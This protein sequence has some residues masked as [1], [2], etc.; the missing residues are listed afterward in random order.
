MK[1]LSI[2]VDESGDFGDYQK[3]CPFYIVSLVFHEQNRPIKNQID[4]LN[5]FLVDNSLPNHTIH[6]APLIRQEKSYKHTDIN[7]RSKIFKQLFNFVR[8][9]DISY[10]TIV[11]DKRIFPAQVDIIKFI[12]KELSS[13]IKDNY[14]YFSRFD[15]IIIYYDNGQI[16]LTKT[17]IAIFGSLLGERSEF[18]VIMPNN[19]KLF[20]AADLICTLTLIKAK[21]SN[22]RELSHS[23]QI[24]FGSVSKLN[25]N[26]LKFLGKIE[27]KTLF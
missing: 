23:E 20:Q 26:Y 5:R 24:F 18:R 12:T 11:A 8:S 1:V 15:S 21:L 10:K 27:F 9:V 2:F 22:G 16:Q 7:L 25:K 4:E 13:F 6:T 14:Q 19:Y 3:H 17:L